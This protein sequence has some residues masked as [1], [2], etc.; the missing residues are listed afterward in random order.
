MGYKAAF[1][2]FS[3]PFL[4]A[5]QNTKIL[6]KALSWHEYLK[7]AK[8]PPGTCTIE[9]FELEKESTENFQRT[10]L[11]KSFINFRFCVKKESRKVV[12]NLLLRVLYHKI[13]P[14]HFKPKSFDLRLRLLSR[15]LLI[16]KKAIRSNHIDYGLSLLRNTEKS[17][18]Q[19]ENESPRRSGGKIVDYSEN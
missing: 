7:A 8:F 4:L 12:D 6:N 3:C 10:S 5:A 2:F 19:L 18:S 11:K 14:P 16:V 1:F 17:L 15:D 13:S 9:L